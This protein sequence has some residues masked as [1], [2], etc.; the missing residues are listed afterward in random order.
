MAVLL[1]ETEDYK[2]FLPITSTKFI[3]DITIGIFNILPP[4]IQKS[5]EEIKE[6]RGQGRSTLPSL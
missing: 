3:W 6:K 1:I 5:I 2:K 4:Q